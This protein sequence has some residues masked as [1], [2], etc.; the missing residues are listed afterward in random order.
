MPSESRN[1]TL[2]I[3]PVCECPHCGKSFRCDDYCD[4]DDS[5]ELDCPNCEETVFVTSV[6]FVMHVTAATMKEQ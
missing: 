1:E 2:N 4:I 3:M 5:T 6:E